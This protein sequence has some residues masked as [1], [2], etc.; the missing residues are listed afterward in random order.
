MLGNPPTATTQALLTI[1]ASRLDRMHEA[2]E[3]AREGL[4]LAVTQLGVGIVGGLVLAGL[5]MA[6]TTSVVQETRLV[7]TPDKTA[8]VARRVR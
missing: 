6:G 2:T 5:L 8:V 1:L 3:R 7:N 4:R